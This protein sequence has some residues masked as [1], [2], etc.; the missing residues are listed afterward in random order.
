MVFTLIAAFGGGYLLGKLLGLD[1]RLSSLISSGTGI[2]GGS[3]I[4]A[5]SP[6][7]E[8]EDH[9]F[10]MPCLL[11]Y[12]DI[13]MII[14]FPLF[15]RWLS[16]SD[17]AYGLW[18]GTAV[19]DT[20]SVV[21]AGYAFSEAAGDFATMVK[22]TRTLSIIPI[23]II[24]S[25]I[26]VH[27]TK[28]KAATTEGHSTDVMGSLKNVFPWFI[29]GFLAMALLNS[30]GFI[31]GVVSVIFKDASKFLMIMALGAIGLKPT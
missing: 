5:V 28:K 24:F 6:I 20:S 9:Q 18:T 10:L 3:A 4:A 13:L 2:C 29:L 22:L 15:G 7:I 17:V 30:V 26:Q 8:A 11:L 12:F 1:W 14:L 21:A 31:P 16:L 23:A 27:L 25:L 19:N